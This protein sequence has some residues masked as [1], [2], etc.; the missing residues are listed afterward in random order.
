M[1]AYKMACDCKESP[2][3]K[4]F[5]NGKYTT[6]KPPIPF[7]ATCKICG[8]KA[9]MTEFE[10]CLNERYLTKCVEIGCHSNFDMKCT[11]QDKETFEKYCPFKIVAKHESK[12]VV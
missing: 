2:V 9:R 12:E 6:L 5:P 4:L 10:V 3:N 8:K 1:K 11:I 7:E